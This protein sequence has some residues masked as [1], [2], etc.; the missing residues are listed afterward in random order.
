ML[1]LVGGEDSL[2]GC[3]VCGD[4]GQVVVPQAETFQTTCSRCAGQGRLR[5][6]ACAGQGT[7]ACARCA[8]TGRGTCERCEG[9][10]EVLSYL[11]VVQTFETRSVACRVSGGDLPGEGLEQ[12]A[13]VGEYT[14]LAEIVRDAFPEPPA[15]WR[16]GGAPPLLAEITGLVERARRGRGRIVRQALSI[17]AAPVLELA[18]RHEGR[19]HVLWLLGRAQQVFAPASPL[20]RR[21]EEAVEEAIALWQEAGWREAALR[22]QDA[23]NTAGNDAP[24]AA[25]LEQLR[26]R[27][28]DE[29]WQRAGKV[30]SDSKQVAYGTALGLALMGVGFGVLFRAPVLL[31]AFVAAGLVL[32]LV[33][34]W[35]FKR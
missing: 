20:T 17:A 1:A 32:G 6:A 5:C 28:P 18:Y 26:E 14:P 12:L 4:S 22:L 7:S 23:R 8:G 19:S 15:A 33:G 2:E 31:V 3:P 10:G 35:A 34:R 13:A 30:L 16:G 27:I 25:V 9:C 21:V 24:C 11:A 29:L